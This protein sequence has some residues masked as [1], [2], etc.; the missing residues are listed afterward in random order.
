MNVIRSKK[1]VLPILIILVGLAVTIGLKLSQPEAEEEKN[2]FPPLTVNV[3]SATFSEQ[4]VSSLFQGEV[5]AKTNIELVTQVTGK[6]VNV[7]DNF[8]EGGQFEEN[9]VL[10]KIDDSDFQVALKLA[11]AS[12]AS[13]Q[14]DLDIELASAATNAREWREL[15][16]KPIEEASPLRLNKPQ[17][18]RARAML[19]AAKAELAAAKLNYQ[20]T[21][22]SAPFAGRIM[23]KTAELGQFMERGASVGR[24]FATNAMEIR[25]PMTDI[26]LGELGIG[27]GYTLSSNKQAPLTATIS[28]DFGIQS[29]QWQGYLK[30]V[31]A[32]IDNE[33]RLLYA[34]VVVEQPLAQKNQQPAPLAPGLF[35]DVELQSP[36]T[37]S[38]IQMPR[39]ALRNGNQ[40]Y[41]VEDKKLRLHEVSVVFTSRDMVIVADNDSS[42]LQS[43]D[44]VVISAVPGAYDGMPVKI[45]TANTAKEITPAA[46]L[47]EPAP[48]TKGDEEIIEG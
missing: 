19:V 38:G 23:T 31:D 28:H 24:V 42:T 32:S 33:T 11:E 44:P 27:L 40:V 48:Q 43:G 3:S 10:L 45:N 13:A 16:K 18:D 37:L 39:T 1:F 22:I 41:V 4:S 15:Q 2:E 30:N 34:T 14:V 12:V 9:E 29:H 25:I 21:Q 36:T 20:R 8:I 5:R 47:E 35:V 26:Q 46:E 7:S 6:V 17:V